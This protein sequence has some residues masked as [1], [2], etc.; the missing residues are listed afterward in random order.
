MLTARADIVQVFNSDV[1]KDKQKG[2][3][4]SGIKPVVGVS[5]RP[6]DPLAKRIPSTRVSTQDILVK[7]SVPGRTGRKRKRGSDEPFREYSPDEQRTD[8]ITAADLLQRLRDNPDAYTVQAVGAIEQTHRFRRLPDFQARADDV[9][10]MRE[11]RQHAILPEYDSLQKFYINPTPG[12]KAITA[13][14][15]PPSF[16]PVEQ[17]YIYEYQQL[18]AESATP[19]ESR[20]RKKGSSKSQR[21]AFEVPRTDLKTER[22]PLEPPE[23]HEES[24]MPD[25]VAAL[26]SVLTDRP[27]LSWNAAAALTGASKKSIAIALPHVG[28][29]VTDGPWS[30]TMIKYGVD[31]RE[32]PKYRFYQSLEYTIGN[33]KALR[34]FM[35]DRCNTPQPHIFSGE[36]PM[37]V[38]PAW[39]LC[40][41]TDPLL[42]RLIENADVR[43]ECDNEK[44][45]WYFNGTIAKIRNIMCDKMIR[46]MH[47]EA[48]LPEEDYEA[49]ATLPEYIPERFEAR[50]DGY[51]KKLAD[52]L[53]REAVTG[54]GKKIGLNKRAMRAIR[55][56]K[57]MEGSGVG[58]PVKNDAEDNGSDLEDDMHEESDEHDD[59][60]VDDPLSH[61]RAYSGS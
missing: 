21:S 51:L 9:H 38:S 24:S 56:G 3:E 36:T 37:A 32:D 46:L 10:I 58:D 5:L 33:M 19:A 50:L 28:Y 7:V 6:N 15:G 43:A 40:D 42:K 60:A 52:A 30:A 59:T 18:T 12:S 31:P 54:Y 61:V 29:L 55:L 20:K 17:P 35:G 14:P 39:Q 47:N 25:L 2:G 27:I 4:E 53:I 8:S 48:L 45:G 23:I 49:L 34:T 57:K 44:W 13:F 11:I 16:L 41:V 26:R 22:V 1:S